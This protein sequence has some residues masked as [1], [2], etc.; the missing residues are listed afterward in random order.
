MRTIAEVLRMVETKLH[1]Q[2]A[3]AGSATSPACGKV[4]KVSARPSGEVAEWLK[5][6]VC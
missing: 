6:A 3:L 1:L 2:A 5:A 4:W